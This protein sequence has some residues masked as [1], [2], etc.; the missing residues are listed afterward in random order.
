MDPPDCFRRLQDGSV[1]H[2]SPARG[3]R[4][5]TDWCWAEYQRGVRQVSPYTLRHLPAH[6][7]AC[8]RND[9]LRR[10]LL[11]F[12]W[13]QAKLMACDINALLDDFRVAPNDEA[14]CLVQS[15]LRMAAH[16]LACD[17][18]Q[19]PSQLTGRLLA[20][21]VPQIQALLERMKDR[22][23]SW[24]R[25]LTASLIAAGG[26]LLRTLEGHTRSVNAVA[27]YADGKRALSASED[28]T[29]RVVGLSRRSRQCVSEFTRDVTTA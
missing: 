14:L 24:L 22:G 13:L 3:E 6:L 27:V 23:H 2:L 8:G 21:Y 10:L 26:P 28:K 11:D 12:E 19:L 9:H 16:V 15:A 5:I 29:V 18:R 25:P 20:H 17:K 4:E 7:A 1:Y